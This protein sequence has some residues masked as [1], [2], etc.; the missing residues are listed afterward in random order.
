MVLKRVKPIM[1]I[2]LKRETLAPYD[3][4]KGVSSIVDILVV[5][6]YF[7][8]ETGSVKYCIH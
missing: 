6:V 7:Y 3:L 4:V 8:V 2:V 5:G 1:G